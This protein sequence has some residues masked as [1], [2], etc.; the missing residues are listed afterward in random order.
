M[1]RARR[2]QTSFAGG[3]LSPRLYGRTDVSKYDAGLRTCLNAVPTPEGAVQNRAGFEYQAMTYGVTTN[4][5]LIPFVYN[6]DQ[7][8]VIELSNAR[9]RVLYRGSPVTVDTG[10]PYTVYELTTPWSTSELSR[11]KF[12]QSG[13]TMILVH[14]SYAPQALRRVSAYTPGVNEVWT[15][16]AY[17]F[18]RSAGPQNPSSVTYPD[19][20]VAGVFTWY[21]VTAL[22]GATPVGGNSVESALKVIGATG[23]ANTV[24][25]GARAQL[26]WTAAAG[27]PTGYNVYKG[28]G[29]SAT[30][31]PTVWGLIG[32]V[33][34]TETA[35]TD[36]GIQPDYTINPPETCALFGSGSN[37]PSAVAFHQ[38][39]LFFGNSTNNPN[40][41]WGS[42]I[43][44]YIT[45]NLGLG[46]LATDA[47]QADIASRAWEEIRDLVPGRTL[48]VFTSATE[49]S[50]AGSVQD[51]A[52]ISPAT[53]TFREQTANGSSWAAPL[54]LA[55]STLHVQERGN[56]VRD[57]V[58]S[59][60]AGGAAGIDLTVLARHLFDGYSVVDWAVTRV[61]HPVIWVVRS[62]G[63]LLSLTYVKEQ[64]VWAWAKHT[65]TGLFTS[66]CVVPEGLED[67][68]Y[69]TVSRV[70][71]GTTKYYIE[72]LASRYVTDAREGVFLDSSKSA[73]NR[74]TTGVTVLLDNQTGWTA[75]S[76]MDATFSSP[77]NPS[78][79]AGE[80]VVFDPDGSPIRLM[81]VSIISGSKY[82]VE[83]LDPVTSAYQAA[84]RTDWAIAYD[85]FSGLSH[86]EGLTVTVLADGGTTTAVVSGGVITLSTPAIIVCAGLPYN[87]DIELLDLADGRAEIKTVHRV[88]FE[89]E[90][91]RGLWVGEDSDDLRE[92]EQQ[93]VVNSYGPIP[94][95][96]GIADV[97]IKNSA[98]RHGRAFLRQA[99]PL[100]LTLLAV[101]REVEFGG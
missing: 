61:P 64:E 7:S 95:F 67:A 90:A 66:V 5:R 79:D 60:E 3:E 81:V 25:S 45:F 51:D 22:G 93:E 59:A 89:V 101:T 26:A 4:S 48:G 97:R 19:A 23:S 74:N 6:N 100:P 2:R 73:D 8:Y 24:T 68:L 56:I 35:F 9:L 42:R 80:W 27:S 20:Y 52:A 98:N 69:A 58:Y 28:T 10:P 72:R 21:G 1:S 62:D 50:M 32:S 49:Y 11:V 63:V 87:S 85:S 46:L 70:V 83:A 14:P 57:L 91:S 36:D 44:D 84:T 34:P 88:H 13:D 39:R 82:R 96:T 43:E 30:I 75:G 54:K 94:L 92:W 16:S 86:L 29:G 18:T 53:L 41:V 71:G 17:S 33:G 76:Q 99:D 47:V 15:L 65:T 78:L 40:R 31:Q 38:G 12:A 37:Y 77:P 55:K